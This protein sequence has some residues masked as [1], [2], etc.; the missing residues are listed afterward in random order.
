ML[1]KRGSKKTRK[2]KS[3]PKVFKYGHQSNNRRAKKG[4]KEEKQCREEASLN[5]QFHKKLIKLEIHTE[6]EELRK[7]LE[8]RVIKFVEYLTKQYKK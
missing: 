5:L 6:A 4:K 2:N 3:Q 1:T 7:E 8:D